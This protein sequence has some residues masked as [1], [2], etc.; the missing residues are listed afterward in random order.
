MNLRPFQNGNVVSADH[1]GAYA[2]Q[3]SQ[4]QTA[5][6][7]RQIREQLEAD[8]AWWVKPSDEPAIQLLALTL[9]RLKQLDSY[10]ERRGMM[11]NKA[12]DLRPAT[13]LMV[14]LVK[15]AQNLFDALGLTPQARMRLG[16]KVMAGAADL[17]AAIAGHS[18]TGGT[19]AKQPVVV[20]AKEPDHDAH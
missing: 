11:A 7:A 9:R 5:A 16:V 15:E 10:L 6:L 13:D 18:D 8:G 17:A 4:P 19:E 2:L 1:H 12:G 14:K 20:D 3:I